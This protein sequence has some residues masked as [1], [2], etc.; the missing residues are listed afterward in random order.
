[1]NRNNSNL[2]KKNILKDDEKIKEFKQNILKRSRYSKKHP[3]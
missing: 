1:M 3:I 2:Q